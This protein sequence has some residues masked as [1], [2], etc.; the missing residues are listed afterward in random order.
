MG[1]L[2]RPLSGEP[3]TNCIGI[4]H[5]SGSLVWKSNLVRLA[6]KSSALSLQ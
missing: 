6:Y 4:S 3:Q 5:A 1:V 2:Y